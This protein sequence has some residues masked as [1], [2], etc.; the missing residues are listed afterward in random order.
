MV[1]TEGSTSVMIQIRVPSRQFVSREHARAFAYSRSQR[2]RGDRIEAL[3]ARGN[4][5]FVS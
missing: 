1:V 2:P 5:R 3:E 4:I